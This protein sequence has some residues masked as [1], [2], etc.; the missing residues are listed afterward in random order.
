MQVTRRA[1]T[2]ARLAV[3]P[4]HAWLVA[5]APLQ[6]PFVQEVNN[7]SWVQWHSFSHCTRYYAEGRVT[8]TTKDPHQANNDAQ[9]SDL[10]EAIAQQKEKQIKAPWHREGSNTPPVARQRSAGAMIK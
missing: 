5:R 1:F 7:S 6:N 2:A 3:G 10:N 4:Q 9:E 8:G